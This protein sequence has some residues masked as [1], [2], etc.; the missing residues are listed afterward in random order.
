MT[1]TILRGKP[2]AGNPHVR[3]DEGEIV[4]AKPRRWSLLY[5]RIVSVGCCLMMFVGMAASITNVRAVPRWNMGIV[6]V[7]YDLY[8]KEGG[9]ATISLEPISDVDDVVMK[10]LSGHV[11]AYCRPGKD[12]HV[13]W[14]ARAD[15]GEKNLS[16]LRIAVS[17]S[18]MDA[19]VSP[20]VTWFPSKTCS[21]YLVEVESYGFPATTYIQTCSFTSGGGFYAERQPVSYALWY[22]VYAWA[23]QRG[24]K[25]SKSYYE[26][27]SGSSISVTAND[28]W[29]WC[30]ARSEME[31]LRPC[32]YTD[33]HYSTSAWESRDS[34][35]KEKGGYHLP[36]YFQ[37]T[38]LMHIGGS[39]GVGSASRGL[40]ESQAGNSCIYRISG[41]AED[42]YAMG[43][44]SGALWCFRGE[45]DRYPVVENIPV[46]F[47]SLFCV[48]YSKDDAA[49]A[50]PDFRIEQ[51]KSKY[52]RGRYGQGNKAT[53][54]A[55]V[56]LQ[57]D[58]ELAVSGGELN[59]VLINGE[60]HYADKF[61]IDVG[62]FSVGEEVVV[63]AVSTEGRYSP[64]Y[65]LNFDIAKSPGIGYGIRADYDDCVVYG[66]GEFSSL[67][68]FEGMNTVGELKM[69]KDAAPI[70]LQFLP[71]IRLIG[72]V[73][74][75]DGKKILNLGAG[76]G[77]VGYPVFKCGR[78]TAYG[79]LTA[80]P[81][82]QWDPSRLLWKNV[83]NGM[84]FRFGGKAVW[85]HH[86]IPG[87][88]SV[89]L[90]GES[91]NF[92][93]GTWNEGS[94]LEYV[95]D[96][97]ILSL[98]LTGVLGVSGLASVEVF[99]EGG[100]HLTY[101]TS[102][103]DECE[104]YF[105]GDVGRYATF[106]GKRYWDKK[107]RKFKYPSEEDLPS[108][109]DLMGDPNSAE[110]AQ[111]VPVPTDRSYLDGGADGTT[112][113]P[114]LI[115]CGV[116]VTNSSY[117]SIYAQ[118]TILQRNGTPDQNPS[119]ANN[120]DGG[121][122]TFIDYINFD[123]PDRSKRNK[124][125]LGT[126]TDD[127]AGHYKIGGRIW[128]DG[129]ADRKPSSSATKG[130]TSIVTWMNVGKVLPED[131][132]FGEEMA[133][134]EIAVAERPHG[135]DE[136]QARNLTEDTAFDHSPIV[137]AWGVDSA[138]VVWIRNEYTNYLGSAVEP[139]KIMFSDY[140][141]ATW[142]DPAPV[143][144]S[145]GKV[146]GI[147]FAAREGFAALSYC[148]CSDDGDSADKIVLRLNGE[149]MA[150]FLL[151]ATLGQKCGA[152]QLLVGT[153]GNIV[154][155]WTKD[156]G[157]HEAEINERGE[158]VE[159]SIDMEG[160]VA[161][162]EFAVA[163]D[164]KGN[165]AVV[166][167]GPSLQDPAIKVPMIM[168]YN[169]SLNIWS[170]ASRLFDR[171][172]VA[173]T[174]TIG[175]PT[176]I[177][178]GEGE[179]K[180]SYSENPIGQKDTRE[181]DARTA[182]VALVSVRQAPD[183]GVVPDSVMVEPS[184]FDVG[185][186][187]KISFKVENLG[188]KPASNVNVQAYVDGSRFALLV[189][190]NVQ[191]MGVRCIK[192][193]SVNWTATMQSDSST[194]VYVSLSTSGDRNSYNNTSYHF[195]NDGLDAKPVVTL[196]S[197]SAE[198]CESNM[199]RIVATVRN[200]GMQ[201]LPSGAIATFR[202][203]DAGG[204]IL[205]QDE[206]GSVSVGDLGQVDVV[207]S[208]SETQ[209]K[210][211]DNLDD[212]FV[213]LSLPTNGSNAI[214]RSLTSTTAVQDNL[215]KSYALILKGAGAGGCNTVLNCVYDQPT[216]LPSVGNSVADCEFQGWSMVENGAAIYKDRATVRNLPM[217]EPDVACLYPV[218]AEFIPEIDQNADVE[219]VSA[220][221]K[222]SADNRLFENVTDV[223]VYGAYRVWA[224]QIGAAKVKASP[225]A[226]ASFATDSAALL[227]KM[228]TDD[229]L[230]VE[231]FKPSSSAGSFDFT[232]S[233]KDVK[234][235]DKASVDNLKK[236]FGL[237]G[238]ESLDSAAFS[239]ENVSLD[240]KKPQDGKLKFAATP[241]VDNAK[242]FFMKVKVK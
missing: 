88:F 79:E 239:S 129:T 237:E 234:I 104:M 16:N 215:K 23:V 67:N 19:N 90:N 233:V 51:V 27:S 186:E 95:Y 146:R 193:Y 189:A 100:I 169:S 63:R 92:I 59:F 48:D 232:V 110:L 72:D 149:W 18:V 192:E 75:K 77:T 108:V 148:E 217:Y 185:D 175:C 74:S 205:G 159:T 222:G 204:A 220:A 207:C 179:L 89:N 2:D 24:Y 202:K 4:S 9:Y 40:I 76:V 150:P 44:G 210:E 60:K 181:A 122:T 225:F 83:S 133:E 49:L 160:E 103:L 102:A 131:A 97:D 119:L 109:D 191:S 52:F 139:N 221:L 121:G 183:I 32:H 26:S 54:L 84:D 7:Y 47:S 154:A 153:N 209:V 69:F 114:Y 45:G 33:Q 171:D 78:L 180:L 198:I 143:V 196:S 195:P 161:P 155:I 140:D 65:R 231:E 226:W 14:D 123:N 66:S 3:F 174:T 6:D 17:A 238:A 41:K 152:P 94:G 167:A 118:K 223:T 36:N 15:N 182:N 113:K 28:A 224:L 111:S 229:D 165:R 208:I 80:S 99:G 230:K 211:G 12:R 241:A 20:N 134:T 187:V 156:G 212:V 218:W 42:T 128:D 197:A 35:R 135:K 145:I 142:S 96:G 194:Y 203:G 117:D 235:G 81:V 147:S 236:L 132:T 184:S 82:S 200:E 29:I 68:L 158:I 64:P 219:A 137:C 240:F 50:I 172:R 214:G 199:C 93:K 85:T 34:V 115:D 57:V 166:W 22:K 206:I 188:D 144:S 37:L 101:D 227:A 213:S 105:Y 87:I 30:N 168:T 106:L 43:G 125:E 216:M 70:N 178:T 127:G 56:S 164:H 162:D 124:D 8:S 21:K 71:S 1:N 39:R 62:S 173:P 157:L 55:G 242:S 107:W 5:K 126:I 10:S 61:S 228:P 120:G 136:W 130:G 138:T 73:N 201:S 13:V 11:G 53:F 91:E 170:S 98:A 176:A 163:C 151:D 46:N 31:G 177:Y 86:F 58:L 190:E 116:I 112:T 25:F 38:Y 141:G